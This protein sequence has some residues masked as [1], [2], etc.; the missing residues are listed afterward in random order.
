MKTV[1]SYCLFDPFNIHVH[2]TWDE[3][4]LDKTRYWFN[5]PALYITNKVLY[6]DYEM[7]IF[8]NNSLTYNPLFKLLEKLDITIEEVDLKFTNTSEPMMWRLIPIWDGNYDC[9]FLRDIDSIPNYQ[10]YVSTTYFAKSKFAIQT[11]RSHENHYHEMG[12]DILGGLCGFKPS[13]IEHKPK[14]FKEYYES[15][16]DMPWA[17]DQF[18]LS[19]TFI[20]QQS[21]LFLET[22]FLDCPIDNQKRKAPFPHSV[23]PYSLFKN[24]EK[25]LIKRKVLSIVKESS[26]ADWAGQPCDARGEVLNKFL[27]LDCDAS[28][29]VK[30]TLDDKV[31][32]DFYG[33]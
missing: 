6:P 18:M 33:V 8:I 19:H 28:R 23:I 29:L 10:E 14:S 17:Q 24:E 15:R 32:K 20:Q 26:L 12:C 4:N 7:K 5:I 9:V 31:L 22:N 3:H 21:P 11:L 25:D 27:E 13:K 2:R 16:M 30:E 1:L